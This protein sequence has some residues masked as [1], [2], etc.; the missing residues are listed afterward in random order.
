MTKTK[1]KHS[2]L[3]V[4]EDV[5]TLKELFNSW[6]FHLQSDQRVL[7]HRVDELEKK[8]KMLEIQNLRRR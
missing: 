8:V 2:F 3:K 1:I 7:Q 4:K 5:L 6:I